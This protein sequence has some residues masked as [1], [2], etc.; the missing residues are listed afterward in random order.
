MIPDEGLKAAVHTLLKSTGLTVAIK[1]FKNDV[2]IDSATVLADLTEADFPGY[3][4]KLTSD[5]VWLGPDI[6]GGGLGRMRSPELV[7]TASSAPG[8]PQ[9]IYGIHIIVVDPGPSSRLFFAEAFAEPIVI[10]LSGDEVKRKVTLFDVEFI[11]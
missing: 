2:T 11:P 7:W 4:S 3:A 8:S 10:T 5:I 1:L 6:D 9:T